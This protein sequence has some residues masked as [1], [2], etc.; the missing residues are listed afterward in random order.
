MA[1]VKSTQTA[2]PKTSVMIT[3]GTHTKQRDE[4]LAVLPSLQTE[5]Q[6]LVVSD[7]DS[8]AYADSLLG[9]LG[10]MRRSWGIVWDRIQEKTI[11]PIRSGL[12][13]LYKM[14][15]EITEP[16][17]ALDST[18]KGKMKAFKEKERLE[19]ARAK[20]TQEEEERK[21]QREL[22]LKIAQE[23]AAKTSAMRERLRVARE[24]VEEQLASVEASKPEEVRGVSSTTRTKPAWRIVNMEL[25][26]AENHGLCLV[27]TVRMNKLFKEHPETVAQMQ[28]V[29]VFDDVSIV[30]R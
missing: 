6:E 17:D 26:A 8:Y 25:F 1:P 10:T 16:L 5:A 15:R 18:V 23:N 22:D 29:E 30:G 19:L 2:L 4:V 3:S 9:R 28:G 27:D 14:N 21:I 11:K 24:K 7:P 12:D 13:E 20:A